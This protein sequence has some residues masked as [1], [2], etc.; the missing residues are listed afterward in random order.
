MPR[1]NTLCNKSLFREVYLL[2]SCGGP[3][4]SRSMR[5]LEDVEE[6]EHG[7]F[8]S[9]LT[10]VGISG[11]QSGRPLKLDSNGKH[12]GN[13]W[14]V[15]RI[16]TCRNT[17]HSLTTPS[18]ISLV[19]GHLHSNDSSLSFRG[20]DGGLNLG[21]SPEGACSVLFQMAWPAFECQLGRM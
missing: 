15:I 8:S 5:R 6:L 12:A 17:L 11:R 14:P 19:H 13:H 1:L 3:A 2:D 7:C 4:R 16:C 18:K 20:S 21:K 9:R 10:A